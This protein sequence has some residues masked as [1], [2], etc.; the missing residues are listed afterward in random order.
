MDGTLILQLCVDALAVGGLYALTALGLG[1]IFSV[2]RLANFAHAELVT[3]GG[4]A[5]FL[6]SDWPVYMA[7]PLAIVA[8]IAVAILTERVA[9]RPLRKADQTTMLIASF[10]VSVFIQRLLI[11]AV[12]SRPKPVDPLPGINAPIDLGG[13]DISGQRLITIAVC[14]VCLLGL[15]WLLQKTSIGLH[16]RAAA[17]DFSMSQ[18]VGVRANEVIIAAFVISGALAGIVAI[19]YTAET[20]FVHPRF[21]VQ[22]VLVGFVATVI[23]G[24][25]SLPGAVLGGFLVGALTTLLQAFLPAGLRDFREAFLFGI[26]ILVLL[27]WPNGILSARSMKERV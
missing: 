6:V 15:R 3:C 21:G 12:G 27:V 19:L 17:E 4:Y 7:L 13:I 5:L 8:A 9:F 2:M 24:L 22:L 18:L 11:F 23:G 1:V 25:G 20:G 16:M 10:T 26:V 14:L